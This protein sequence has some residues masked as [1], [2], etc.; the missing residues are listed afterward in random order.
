MRCNC[1]HDRH[2]D[3]AGN[4]AGCA[5][6]ATGDTRAELVGAICEECAATCFAEDAAA[7]K[8]H[9]LTPYAVTRTTPS[10]FTSCATCH[11]RGHVACVHLDADDYMDCPD[12][13]GGGIIDTR[14]HYSP[15]FAQ[16]LAQAVKEDDPANGG[17]GI[18]TID[19]DAADAQRLDEIDAYL[20][21]PA[22]R[23]APCGTLDALDDERAELQRR[24]EDRR[25]ANTRNAQH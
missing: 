3:G 23:W 22:A 11:G 10:G 13:D 17:H 21:S 1:E 12:C 25:I 8:A 2:D 9:G 14:P 5:H 19:D 6:D 16:W 15:G 24:I 20:A 4:F 18:L 7:A